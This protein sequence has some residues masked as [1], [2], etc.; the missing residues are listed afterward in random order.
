MS[1]SPVSSSSIVSTVGAAPLSDFGGANDAWYDRPLALWTQRPQMRSVS[2]ASGTSSATTLLTASPVSARHSSSIL[3][4]STVRGK[5]SRMNPWPQSASAMRSLMM[6]TTMSSPTRPPLSMT[7]LAL[8]P[9][10]VPAATAARSM[11]PVLSCGAPSLSTS[12][13]ACVPLP[14]PGGPKMTTT[15]RASPPPAERRVGARSGRG[16][17]PL[18][19]F[20]AVAASV[21]VAAS[22]RVCIW[23]LWAA[24]R[25]TSNVAAFGLRCGPKLCGT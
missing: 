6:P 5:P 19:P 20:V 23:T 11:S 15:L 7:L 4:C 2:T 21:S 12:L 17:R 14:A 9:T 10:S 8:L 13:G 22:V 3:A 1:G 16:P 25:C 18:K 24:V